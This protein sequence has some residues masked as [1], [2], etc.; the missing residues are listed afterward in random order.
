VA[1][2]A[3]GVVSW[4]QARGVEQRLREGDASI[5]SPGNLQATLREGRTYEGTAWVLGGLG[6]GAL[7]T[8][9]G[10][11]LWGGNARPAAAGVMLVPGEQGL[12][13]V[14]RGGFQ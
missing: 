9:A 14:A 11:Y 12:G 6:V 3:G 8:A 7:V 2:T 5:T 10:M 13:V 1:L 4:M